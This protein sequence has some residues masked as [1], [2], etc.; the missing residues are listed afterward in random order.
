MIEMNVI[1][2]ITKLGNN[3]AS[4]IRGIIPI[5]RPDNSES[6]RCLKYGIFIRILLKH[7]TTVEFTVI[8]L[9]W[10]EIDKKK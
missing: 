8:S 3:A 5:I 9:I 1:I 7:N 4:T 10:L 2:N 6:M